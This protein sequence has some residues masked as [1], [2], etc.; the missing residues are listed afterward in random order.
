M[1]EK[2][3]SEIKNFN[4]LE[5]F[6]DVFYKYVRENVFNYHELKKAEDVNQPNVAGLLKILNEM[7]SNVFETESRDKMAEVLMYNSPCKVSN[8]Y[9]D[10]HEISSNQSDSIA[11]KGYS[12]NSLMSS[13]NH[14]D[15][16]HM[17]DEEFYA[18]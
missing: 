17:D 6:P 10:I 4:P 13:Q 1:K 12:D 14:N 11:S 2:I 15:N 8:N 7:N 3:D 9:N 16:V 18:V 5:Y